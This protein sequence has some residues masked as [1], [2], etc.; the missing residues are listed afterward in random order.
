MMGM[1]LEK[2]RFQKFYAVFKDNTTLVD[3]EVVDGMNVELY[4]N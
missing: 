1:R 2:L 3:C 4:Y